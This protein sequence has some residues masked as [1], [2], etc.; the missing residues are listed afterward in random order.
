MK[1]DIVATIIGSDKTVIVLLF[2]ELNNSSK[3]W[4]GYKKIKQIL[5]SG[6]I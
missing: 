1:E 3:H 2:E 4:G 6:R 5:R